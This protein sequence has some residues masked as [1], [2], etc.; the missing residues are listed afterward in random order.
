LLAAL[1]AADVSLRRFEVVVPTLHQ[2]FVDR[3]GGDAATIAER[4]ADHA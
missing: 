1:V 2:I 4:T 3:V